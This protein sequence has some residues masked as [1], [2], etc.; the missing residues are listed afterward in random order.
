MH[1][2]N[3]GY[4]RVKD[5]DFEIVG[6]L[7]ADVSFDSDY[8]EFLMDKF[9][10]NPN[11][12]VGGTAFHEGGLAYNYEFVGIEHVSGMCQLFRRECFEDINGYSAIK[13]GESI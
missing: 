11:L 12:G 2:F 1:A 4:D 3:A 7:D 6:N 9:A 8:S 13:S 5:L 10:G